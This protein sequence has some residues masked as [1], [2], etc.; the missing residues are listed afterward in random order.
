MD[1]PDEEAIK[2]TADMLEE[3]RNKI[4]KEMGYLNALSPHK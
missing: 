3:A 4:R 2:R 1:L